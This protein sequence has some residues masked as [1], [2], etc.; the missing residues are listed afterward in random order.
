VIARPVICR[1]FVGRRAE[2]A[3]LKERRLEAGASRGGLVFVAGDAGLGK[4]RLIDE[5]CRSLA[6]SRWRIT[7][8]QCRE[9]G[10]RPYGPILDALLTVDAGTV[11]LTPAESK[12]QYFED[13]V[14]GFV[15]IAARKALVVV[16]ED[17]H[18]ADAATLDLLAYLG[19]R[20]ARMRV[21]LLASFRAD[22]LHVGHPAAAAIEKVGRSANAGR[23]DLTGLQGLELRTFIDEAL[24][25]FLLDD[26]RRREI[27]LAG[28][29]NPFFTEE[30]L[31]NAVQEA[32]DRGDRG[33]AAQVPP[34]VRTTLLERLRPFAKREREII[35][36]AAVI[37]RTFSL[38][39]LASVAGKRPEQLL[40]ALRR[41]RDFQLIEEL[42]PDVFRF[43]HGLTREAICG[44]FLRTELRPLHRRIARTLEDAPVAEHTE[45]GLPV[46]QPGARLVPGAVDSADPDGPGRGGH[47]FNGGAHRSE[48]PDD[49]VASA[50]EFDT[51]GI[52][53][54]PRD[55]D[56]V[57]A[58][59]SNHFGGVHAGRSHAQETRGT[60]NE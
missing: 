54:P 32:A 50:A 30:L 31:K 49:E 16:I 29:G 42:E 56:A 52:P 55:P 46:R 5:L 20:I 3:Y 11:R 4:S 47:R 35:T 23:I 37:G 15:A 28:E 9:F 40:S 18:W 13:I 48:D 53:I 33:R 36:Q 38:G 58:S 12:R 19:S 34:G 27:A 8:G 41:A 26:E 60:D 7:R 21:L 44:S 51:G 25:G 39:L 6:Y 22:A 57:R 43:R 14:D 17:L 1:A 59:I 24:S 45:E 10:G 2:L